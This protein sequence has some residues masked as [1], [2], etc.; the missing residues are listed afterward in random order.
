MADVRLVVQEFTR[1]GT[2]LVP[3][4]KS[5]L[6]TDTYFVPNDGRTVVHFLNTG[7]S[8][9][10]VTVVTPQTVDGQA[11]ADPTYTVA[12][13]SGNK[14]IGPFPPNTYNVATTGE[15]SFTLTNPE[16]VSCAVFR[17]PL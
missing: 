17:M 2:G 7:G 14:F 10:V 11:V 12:L 8:N 4:Y 1:A 15:F 16:D 3:T 6:T 9:S 13:T 5:D